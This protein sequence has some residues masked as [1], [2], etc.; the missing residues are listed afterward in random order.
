MDNWN[1]KPSDELYLK[2]KDVY[3]N[4]KYFNQVT[5]DPI[6]PGT[7]GFTN[8][9]YTIETMHP[10]TII[11]RYGSNGNGQYFS[12]VGTSYGERALPPFMETQPYTQYEILK[13]F[14]VQSGTVAPF[15][16]KTGSIASWFD[17]PG[18]GIQYFS[19]GTITVLDEITGQLI[20]VKATVE[21]LVKYGFLKE[22][23]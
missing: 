6:Y 9:K 5:G 8:G 12:P 17:Q 22:L 21:N 20:E 3:D 18:G 19:E 16:V 11:D 1:Y 15:E 13:P 7:N 23:K 10:G 4:P 14:D 2:Y